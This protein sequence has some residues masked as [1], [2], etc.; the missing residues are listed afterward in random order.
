MKPLFVLPLILL[1]LIT[2]VIG[3][4]SKGLFSGEILQADLDSFTANVS[5]TPGYLSGNQS[6]VQS[7][8]QNLQDWMD[9]GKTQLKSGSWKPAEDAFSKV[10]D[11]EPKNTE[12][13]EGYLLAIRGGGNFDALLE[14]SERAT[15]EIPD[16]ASAWKYDGIPLRGCVKIT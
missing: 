16:F 5:N 2:P 10:I 3:D 11:Q 7:S 6:E 9:I 13:W 1:L 14:A 8:T 4:K 15:K 12:G